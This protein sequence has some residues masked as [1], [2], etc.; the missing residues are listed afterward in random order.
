MA[1]PNPGNP[2]SPDTYRSL[3]TRASQEC[4]HRS[5]NLKKALR[6]ARKAIELEPDRTMAYQLLGLAHDLTGDLHEAYKTF[7]LAAER[8][9]PDSK[10]WVEVSTFAI[11]SHLRV[12]EIVQS[13][14]AHLAD[15][16]VAA[17]CF[18]RV[19]KLCAKVADEHEDCFMRT[20]LRHSAY[21]YVSCI[22]AVSRRHLACITTYHSCISAVSLLY[23][24]FISAAVSLLYLACILAAGALRSMSLQK[25]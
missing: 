5:G 14:H 4:S 18:L 8:F 16:S 1:S 19:A 10:A 11:E 24:G 2:G 13:C 15:H 9:P 17:A 21:L 7:L 12:R 23:H 25:R 22:S 20:A 6:S 3:C